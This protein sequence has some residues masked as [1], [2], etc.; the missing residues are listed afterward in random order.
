[1]RKTR[2]CSLPAGQFS[3]TACVYTWPSTM[4]LTPEGT[5]EIVVVL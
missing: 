2:R 1:V 4:N 5:V 3:V